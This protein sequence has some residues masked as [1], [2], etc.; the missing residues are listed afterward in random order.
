MEKC[1]N[2]SPFGYCKDCQ[3][4]LSLTMA[5]GMVG[6]MAPKSETTQRSD[7]LFEERQSEA[8][9]STVKSARLE[10]ILGFSPYADGRNYQKWE[11]LFLDFVDSPN[12]GL[13][14]LGVNN[15]VTD[16]HIEL[17]ELSLL[18]GNE[19]WEIVNLIR[20]AKT[21]TPNIDTL[22][23]LFDTITGKNRDIRAEVWL[24]TFKRP[25]I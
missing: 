25:K 11:Y 10:D 15:M 2:C 1:P 16:A 8:T 6:Q 20:S 22:G 12:K 5:Q 9:G 18:L 14:L 23:D 24:V 4:K 3:D 17:S 21:F 13:L 19:G 7:S